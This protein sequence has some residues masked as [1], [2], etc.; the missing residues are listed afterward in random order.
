MASLYLY[1]NSIILNK[2]KT[3]QNLI[4]ARKCIIKEISN[5]ENDIF[6]TLNHIQGIA[7]SK[8]K[9][10]L[11][12]QDELVSLISFG[13]PRYNDNFEYELIRSCSKL[14]TIVIG[15]FDRLFK[16]FVDVYRPKNIITYCDVRYFNGNGYLNNNFKYIKLTEPDYFYFK[17]KDM[18]LYHR[19][20]FQKHKLKFILPNYDETKTAYENMLNN[21]YLRI[22]DAGNKVFHWFNQNQ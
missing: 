20:I 17:I 8:I 12:Y 2:L 5:K 11:Y 6:C 10:G 13:K 7:S 9:L 19:T 15:G 18:V 4:P 3:N 14:N 16:Y 22:F 1:T 21:G